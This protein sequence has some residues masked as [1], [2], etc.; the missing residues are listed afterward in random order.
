MRRRVR[1]RVDL[2]QKAVVAKNAVA[3]REDEC[4]RARRTEAAA[5]AGH[6]VEHAVTL[7]EAAALAIG[8]ANAGVAP[9][10]RQKVGRQLL[11]A[12]AERAVVPRVPF[13]RVLV[14]PQ[15]DRASGHATR[16]QRRH[17]PVRP[18]RHAGGRERDLVYIRRDLIGHEVR[19]RQDV[20]AGCVVVEHVG[21]EVRTAIVMRLRVSETDTAATN[22]E[23]ITTHVV[24]V[25]AATEGRMSA[26]SSRQSI[27]P[28]VGEE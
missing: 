27:M 20:R 18:L 14:G 23:S 24:A 11:Q 10:R 8:V 9:R 22:H 21:L 28:I 3:R 5:E 15:P 2:R 17:A 13:A 26:D 25:S 7:E 4:I 1:R 6:Q 19:P 12:V 16:L